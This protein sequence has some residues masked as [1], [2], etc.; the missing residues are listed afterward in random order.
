MNTKIG[1]GFSASRSRDILPYTQHIKHRG[2]SQCPCPAH[3][4]SPIDV[5]R[6]VVKS[7][8]PPPLPPATLHLSHYP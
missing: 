4:P 3:A 5:R 7:L 2:S 1:T 6:V 8:S